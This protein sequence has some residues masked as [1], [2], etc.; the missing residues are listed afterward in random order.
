MK[1]DRWF[2]LAATLAFPLALLVSAGALGGILVSG[3]YARE[4]A[5]WAAQGIGQDW[6]DLL[7]VAP[8]LVA[9]ALFVRRGS[10]AWAFILG[11][12]F[13]YATYSMVLYAFAV[14][15]NSLFLV[16]S[17][18]L[19]VSSYGVVVTVVAFASAD[20]QTWF[21]PR[22]PVRTVGAFTAVIGLAFYA[23]WLSEVIPALV[24]HGTP[25][26]VVDAGLITNPV[27]VLDIGVVLP[28]FIAGGIAL[29]RR[30]PVGYWLASSM[31]AFGVVMDL[32]LMG[33][34]ISMSLRGVPDSG[35]PLSMIAVLA[36]ATAAMLWLL[37]RSMSV[38][39]R[40]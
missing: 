5:T 37:L 20:V 29:A 2:H 23:L 24:T 18:G 13:V 14:H 12:L 15:F 16:Y 9:A 39:T 3:V 28:A 27:Q 34:V 25:K 1:P 10:R 33:M 26:S 30:R 11:G 8:M 22:A 21:S 6:V 31:L 4:S 40:R 32:A 19:G 7:V 38:S 36:F 17:L 35:P